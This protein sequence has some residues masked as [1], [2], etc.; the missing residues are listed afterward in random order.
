MKPTISPSV[1][2]LVGFRRHAQIDRPA[3]QDYPP[4]ALA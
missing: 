2:V 1:E 3:L 4:W